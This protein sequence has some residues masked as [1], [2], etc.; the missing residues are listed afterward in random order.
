VHRLGGRRSGPGVLGVC[1]AS[2]VACPVAT[3]AATAPRCDNL[4]VICGRYATTRTAADLTALFEAL[5]VSGGA[6]AVDYNV[7]PTDPVPVIRMSAS[8]GGRVLDVAR[9]GLVPTWATDRRVGARMIN[10][11]AET[12]ASM[13][14]FAI[15][16][17]RR[18]CLIPATGWYEFAPRAGGGTS[19]KATRKQPY[20]MTPR[21]GGP[22]V[23][24]GVWTVWSSPDG[25]IPKLL[26]SSIVTTA[27]VGELAD[28]HSRMPLVL[29]PDRWPAWLTA[30]RDLDALLAPP[31]P[32][33]VAA[34]E[35]RAVGSA[36]GDVRNDGPAL[37]EPVPG[38]PEG[39]S[40]RLVP[41]PER[42]DLTLF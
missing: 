34:L 22:V 28:V 11:R 33:D 25:L 14:A 41:N 39:G 30:S 23:F 21:D 16:F 31:S 10:A 3:R 2:I 36:V 35:I 18:R 12:I 19:G 13:K 40:A 15:P 6:I 29:S 9:W 4:G 8:R 1:H 38:Y 32:E 17:A 37:I 5:D 24:A 26:T 7:A 27:A 20:F 42:A